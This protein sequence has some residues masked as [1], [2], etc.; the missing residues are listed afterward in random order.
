MNISLVFVQESKGEQ[1]EQEALPEPELLANDERVKAYMVEHPNAK[2]REIAQALSIS[3]STPNKW[4]RQ[5][6]DAFCIP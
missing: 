6:L 4:I 2:V 1:P 3:T 5:L